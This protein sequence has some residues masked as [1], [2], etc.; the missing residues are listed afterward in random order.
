MIV[1][2]GKGRQFVIKAFLETIKAGTRIVFYCETVLVCYAQ[3]KLKFFYERKPG[4]FDDDYSHELPAPIV[5]RENRKN[6]K[7]I[8]E[9]QEEKDSGTINR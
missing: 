1:K 8:E 3:E 9:I 7:K 6:R 5:D 2:D 4:V